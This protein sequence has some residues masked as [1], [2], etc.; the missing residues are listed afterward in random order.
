MDKNAVFGR[1]PL[2]S[3]TIYHLRLQHWNRRGPSSIDNEYLL[4]VYLVFYYQALHTPTLIY[5]FYFYRAWELSRK[6]FY[7]LYMF[8]RFFK[9]AAH[10][11]LCTV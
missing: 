3:E 5:I 6:G 4:E 1:G 8:S 7:K 10:E 11:T 9:K 2:L